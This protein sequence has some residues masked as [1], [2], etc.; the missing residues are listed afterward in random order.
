MSHNK[1]PDLTGRIVLPGDPQYHA[2][3][4]EFNT[5]FNRFPLVIVFAQETQDVVNAIRWA[6]YRAVPLRMRSGRHNYEGLSVVDAGIV[7]DVSEMKQVKVDHQRGTVTVQTGL[8]DIELYETLGAEGLVVPAGLCPTTGIAG[9]T[10]G[11]GQSSLSRPWG[12]I[13]DNLLELE[14]VD[15]NGNVL[16][17]NADQ[18]PD[19]FWASRGGGG[20]NFGI[21]TSFRFRT[22]QIDTVAYASINWKL[23]DLEPVLRTWQNYTTP[24][25]DERL[26]PLLTITS[27]EQSL[28]LM[29]GVFLGSA[30]KLRRLLEPLLRAGS[31]Q[32]VTIEEI[33]W[34]KAVSLIAATQP[35]SP[36]P[37]K[38]VGPFVDHLLPEEG[39]ATIRRFINEPPQASTVTVFF[40][41]LGGAVARVPNT[42][43]AYFYREALSNMSLF[44][45]WS[46]QE[47]IAPGIRWVE[48]F[49]RAMLP[50]TRGVYVNTPDLSIKNWP[51]AYYGGNFGRLTRVKA[52]YDPENVFRFPQSI[53]PA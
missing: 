34:L 15:A 35:T 41:G 3:R 21:C 14:M 43:T 29:Q 24:D 28:L 52:K 13:I 50:F 49:R 53:P 25:A 39:I 45:T 32:Q 31:P 44:A 22:H 51:E 11:G 4:L 10:L 33:P 26:T 5:F 18:H 19:L 1:E 23:Q 16:Y 17:A 7:I 12:L 8:R 40:H 6:H 20:G 36:L 9:F 46:A 38:S 37:F 30:E 27:G 47:G 48:D 2:A 42:A